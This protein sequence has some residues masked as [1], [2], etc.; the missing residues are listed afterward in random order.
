M[1]LGFNYSSV[2]HS[3]NSVAG[4]HVPSLLASAPVI[5]HV[6]LDY[7]LE[8]DTIV[9]AVTAAVAV[10][11]AA[12][13]AAVLPAVVAA[14]SAAVLVA[15]VALADAPFATAVVAVAATA[16]AV[17]AAVGPHWR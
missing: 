9:A 2:R 13:D 6:L 16:V 17:A 8:A 7:L 14:R 1:S 4:H 15:L 10:D 11:V 3:R 5:F 12:A